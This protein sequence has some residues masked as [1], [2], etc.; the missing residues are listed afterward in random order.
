MRKGKKFSEMCPFRVFDPI[1]H[2]NARKH[3]NHPIW[4]N[5]TTLGKNVSLVFLN[6]IRTKSLKRIQNNLHE[7]TIIFPKITI[8][9]VFETII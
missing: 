6:F 1:M 8:L 2:Y 4:E 9:S 5:K 3:R 7:E